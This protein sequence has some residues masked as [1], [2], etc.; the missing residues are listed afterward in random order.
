ME[1]RTRPSSPDEPPSCREQRADP[2]LARQ[3]TNPPSPNSPSVNQPVNPK[4]TSAAKLPLRAALSTQP[5]ILALCQVGHSPVPQME[6]YIPAIHEAFRRRGHDR[7]S[8]KGP[9][10]HL[11]PQHHHTGR[12]DGAT[13]V[14]L[15][16]QGRNL[17]HPPDT[18]HRNPP[19]HGLHPLR[20]A[21]CDAIHSRN[22]ER[23]ARL[24]AAGFSRNR[25]RSSGRPILLRMWRSWSGRRG[26]HRNRLLLLQSDRHGLECAF[27][28]AKSVSASSERALSSNYRVG[29]SRSLSAHC[30]HMSA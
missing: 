10:G 29:A 2:H 15:P 22:E 21:L 9:P 28:L 5:L 26:R 23:N 30:A 27:G 17:E 12:A 18:G 8:R 7:M 13:A 20:R 6:G 11:H 19:N 3:P 24:R 1:Y 4:R 14:G 25:T 16:E